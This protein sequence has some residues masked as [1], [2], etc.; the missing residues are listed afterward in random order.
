MRTEIDCHDEDLRIR[1]EQAVAFARRVLEPKV[2][3]ILDAETAT[4]GGPICELAVIDAASGQIL[5]DT[6]VNPMVPIT[7]DTSA[8]H[9]LTDSMVSAPGVPAWPAVYTQLVAVA[10]GR[11]LLAYNASYDFNVVVAD[12][13]RY[14]LDDS[15]ITAGQNWEDV[16]APRSHHAYSRRWLRNDGGHRALGD[17]QQTRRHLMAMTHP[18]TWPQADERSTTCS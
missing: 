3:V 6:L 5:I 9:G 16:M 10:S 15:W 4:L 2:A 12:C 11:I 18:P 13:Q 7:A 14:G 8:I 1:A 17:V